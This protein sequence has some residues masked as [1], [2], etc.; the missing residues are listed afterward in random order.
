ML[1]V[2]KLAWRCCLSCQACLAL[3]SVLPSLLGVVVCLAKFTWRCYPAHLITPT[4]VGNYRYLISMKILTKN[5]DY[6]IRALMFL[7]EKP[8]VFSPARII[9]AEAGIPLPFLRRILQSLISRGL[10]VS[11]EGLTGGV[12][13]AV[14]PKNIRLDR[15]I[16]IFQG[17]IQFSECLFRKRVCANRTGCVLRKRL[18]QIEEKFAGEFASISIADL[19]E[20]FKKNKRK[21]VAK[22][23]WRG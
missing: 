12:R 18:K 4:K 22:L 10:I 17:E 8:D 15:L 23:A 21:V 9:S 2:A 7:A 6:A 3:L 13:L 16:Q 1:V 20:D 5:T 11:R 14:K 19:I